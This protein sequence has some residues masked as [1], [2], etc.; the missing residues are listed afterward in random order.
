MVILR[1]PAY[2]VDYT[3]GPA[4]PSLC[5][6]P[7]NE[8]NARQVAGYYGKKYFRGKV[9]T[10]TIPVFYSLW[11]IRTFKTCDS[12]PHFKGH[13]KV[14]TYCLCMPTCVPVRRV[15]EAVV[16]IQKHILIIR[17]NSDPVKLPVNQRSGRPICS[18]LNF[19]Q[20]F[21]VSLSHWY[22]WYKLR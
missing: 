8:I 5:G 2:H 6:S 10:R 13:I 15:I 14:I 18:I 19:S 1:I 16:S 3:T 21:S 20:V 4:Y 9:I 22:L 17:T 7:G 11:T 12:Q